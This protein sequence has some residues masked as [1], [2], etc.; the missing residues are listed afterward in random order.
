MTN[1][2]RVPVD[3]AD[4]RRAIWDLGL[5]D[6]DA[7]VHASLSSFGRVEGGAHAVVTPLIDVCRTVLVPTFTFESQPVVTPPADD[8]PLQN[9]LDYAEEDA[10]AQANQQPPQPINLA[11]LASK[12]CID[13]EMGVIPRTVLAHPAAVRSRHPFQSFAAVGAK[14]AEY[15]QAHPDTDPLLPLKKLYQ[16]EGQILLI[17]CDL[18]SCTAIHL[19]EE[20]AGRNPFIRWYLAPDGSIRRVAFCGCSDG[21]LNLTRAVSHLGTRVTAGLCTMVCYPIKACVDLCATLIRDNPAITRCDER[22]GQG[23]HLCVDAVKG[24]PIL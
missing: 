4:I 21:F 2:D 11:Q 20:F 15:M 23:C 8:R 5:R 9:G 14:A 18:D 7:V 22:N 24:G 10:E 17:G 19:A 6:K 13:R 1:Q 12:D 16:R 3:Q